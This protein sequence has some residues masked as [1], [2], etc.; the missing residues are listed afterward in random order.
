MDHS[1]TMK[2]SSSNM[3]MSNI[4]TTKTNAYSGEEF[5]KQLEAMK[6]AFQKQI[7]FLQ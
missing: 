7:N 3:P 2:E 6:E 5:N 4:V 1:V